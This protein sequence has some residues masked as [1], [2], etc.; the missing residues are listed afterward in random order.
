M[1]QTTIPPQIRSKPSCHR[2]FSAL[3]SLAEAVTQPAVPSMLPS[4]PPTTT[5]ASSQRRSCHDPR[6]TGIWFSSRNDSGIIKTVAGPKKRQSMTAKE[7]TEWR[8]RRIHAHGPG[9]WKQEKNKRKTASVELFSPACAEGPRE[10]SAVRTH[11]RTHARMHV[12][13]NDRTG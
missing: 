6:S 5:V 8:R 7:P 13:S 12:R 3:K 4:P 2:V 11:A 9:R 1:T 10:R